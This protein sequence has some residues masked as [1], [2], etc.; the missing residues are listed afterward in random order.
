MLKKRIKILMM[1]IA[2]LCSVGM[3]TPAS[4]VDALVA[5]DD[6]T[7]DAGSWAQVVGEGSL[8]FIDPKLEKGR[9]WVEGQARACQ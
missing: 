9:I 6:I 2:A 5:N 7:Q 3:L 4:A 1:A 8:K